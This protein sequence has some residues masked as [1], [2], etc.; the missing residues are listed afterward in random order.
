MNEDTKTRILD[1]AERLFAEGGFEGTSLRQITAA[2][3][4]NLAAV[5]YHFRSKDALIEALVARRIEKINQ[6]RIE[7]LT[8]LERRPEPP[9]V[10]ELIDA[11][12]RPMVEGFR[13]SGKPHAFGQIF[14]RMYIESGD[15]MKRTL[16]PML[17]GVMA[18]FKAALSRVLPGYTEEDLHWAL[19]FAMGATSHYLGAS[20]MLEVMS[21]GSINV[22]DRMAGLDRLVRFVAAGVRSQ[23]SREAE[24]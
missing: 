12:I 7:R 22:A 6:I 21:N 3:Q 5:N 4:A 2:A 1:A 20:R 13:E 8:E 11:A 9:T 10:E 23:C 15:R 24:V 19:H 14:G 16:W 17:A 18:K